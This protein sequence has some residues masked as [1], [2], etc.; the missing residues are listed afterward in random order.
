MAPVF[1]IMGTPAC[2]K[3]MVW[4]SSSKTLIEQHPKAGWAVID[5]ARLSVEQTV[6]RMLEQAQI[7]L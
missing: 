4:G 1:L 2:G 5:S 7:K 6:E 3:S